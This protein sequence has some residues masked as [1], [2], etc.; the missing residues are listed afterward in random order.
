MVSGRPA[1]HLE[2]I[3]YAFKYMLQQS[4]VNG[5]IFYKRKTELD[6]KDRKHTSF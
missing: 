4:Q 1:K 3:P 2:Y 5:C 6:F